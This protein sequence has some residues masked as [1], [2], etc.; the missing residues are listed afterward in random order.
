MSRFSRLLTAAGAVAML[1][2][3]AFGAF[4][5]HVLR[6]RLTADAMAVFHTGVEYHF[7]HALG[8]MLI[9]QLAAVHAHSRLL[10]WAGLLVA[11]GIVLFSGT[12]YAIALTGVRGWGAIT[13]FG[14]LAWLLAWAL[15]A[16]AM[17]RGRRS[18]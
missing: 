16:A 4:G 10:R 14:G 12:L 2:A 18:A 11:A 15:V 8:L 6:N 13:P 7:Y 1:C 3:V 17:W 9:G 5:A